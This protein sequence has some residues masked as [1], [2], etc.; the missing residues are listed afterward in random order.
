MNA[1]SLRVSEFN[2]TDIHGLRMYSEHQSTDWVGCPALIME[3]HAWTLR[4]Y[5]ESNGYESYDRFYSPSDLVYDIHK[6]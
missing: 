5:L 1:R 3:V 4:A 2:T 6:H